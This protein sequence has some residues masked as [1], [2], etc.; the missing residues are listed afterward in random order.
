MPESM[1]R[2]LRHF[3]TK[4]ST[5]VLDIAEHHPFSQLA[6]STGLEHEVRSFRALLPLEE[7]ASKLERERHLALLVALAPDG[8][9]H[10]LEVYVVPMQVQGFGD[11]D[12]RVGEKQDERLEPLTGFR[13]GL[14]CAEL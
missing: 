4:L 10:V 7:E 14:P 9:Q 8:D 11:A 13:L 1:E 12:A 6:S 5:E 2:T 3:D